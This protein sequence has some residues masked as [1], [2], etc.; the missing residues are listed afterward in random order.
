MG[1]HEIDIHDELLRRARGI[2]GTSSMKD[3]VQIALERVI[4]DEHRRAVALRR[5]MR[6]DLVRRSRAV[7]E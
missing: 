1:R 5:A 3:T 4:E 2:L 6:A 7:G